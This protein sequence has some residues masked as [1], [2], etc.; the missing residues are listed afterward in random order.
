MIYQKIE[1]NE[2]GS[3]N[4]YATT[5][6]WNT[7]HE[8]PQKKRPTIVI[9]PGGAYTFVSYREG[10]PVAFRF[11]SMG[12]NVVVLRYSVYPDATYPTALNELGRVVLTL[13]EHSDEWL[14]DKE[15]IILMGFSAGGHLAGLFSCVWNRSQLAESLGCSS[16]MLKPNG[17][18]LGYPVINSG[19]Y[20]HEGTFN[21]LLGDRFDE[22]VEQMSLENQITKDNPPTFL[23]HTLTDGIV[24][25]E[26]SVIFAS[27]LKE[28]GI[29][30]ELHIYSEGEHGLS[31][32]N[33]I[34]AAYDSQIL[35]SCQ[36]WVDLVHQWV[37]KIFNTQ[38]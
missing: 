22:L 1:L 37:L 11:L 28:N 38:R 20:A 18:V 14:I 3:K 33:E 25:V 30:A 23:W 6:I 31:L 5:Y 29:S 8:L 32:A 27:A 10:E 35:P 34:T 4:S 36:G 17:L 19:K 7:N 15:K 24:P 21:N 26:N 2:V 13:R 12:Y 16:D 9:C